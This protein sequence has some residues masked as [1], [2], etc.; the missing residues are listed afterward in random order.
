MIKGYNHRVINQREEYMNLAIMIGQYNN[1]K[2]LRQFARSYEKAHKRIEQSEEDIAREKLERKVLKELT[3][4]A[5]DKW[6]EEKFL[7]KEE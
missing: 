5:L 7:N 1:G 3:E 6:T 4:K 2:S